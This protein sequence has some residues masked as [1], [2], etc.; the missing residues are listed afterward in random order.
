MLEMYGGREQVGVGEGKE[1][2]LGVSGVGREKRINGGQ[3][4]AFF[5]MCQRPGTGK[6]LGS[7]WGQL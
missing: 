5:K 4:E 2:R 3:R 6:A 7:L 1:N